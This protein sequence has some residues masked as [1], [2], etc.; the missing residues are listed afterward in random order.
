[1]TNTILVLDKQQ[2]IKEVTKK[3]FSENIGK[4][5]RLAFLEKKQEVIFVK[6]PIW[7]LENFVAGNLEEVKD[8]FIYEIELND[9]K[10]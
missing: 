5:K 8:E 10:F 9:Y 3:Q 6:S 7:G 2:E 1:M 4:L